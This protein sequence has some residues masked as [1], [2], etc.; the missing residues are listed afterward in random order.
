MQ[1][2]RTH[3]TGSKYN[4]N[5]WSSSN[6][7]IT[8]TENVPSL[9]SA[10][11][12]VA[13]AKK[14]KKNSQLFGSDW[15]SFS[16]NS[17]VKCVAYY[18]LLLVILVHLFWMYLVFFYWEHRTKYIGKKC[19]VDVISKSTFR[20]A[21]SMDACELIISIRFFLLNM[22]SDSI[23]LHICGKI[24]TN[25]AKKKKR[26]SIGFCVSSANRPESFEYKLLSIAIECTIR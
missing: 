16:F 3:G 15:M 26:L 14:R 23:G 22:K 6:A 2:T 20:Y 13:A 4:A 25:V 8:R 17:R 5:I 11:V 7:V 10:T 24:V 19:E 1:S 9:Q 21:I 18:S 12:A